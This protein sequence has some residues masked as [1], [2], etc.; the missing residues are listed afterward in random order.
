MSRYNK[1]AP[2]PHKAYDLVSSL[3]RCPAENLIT[4]GDFSCQIGLW[5]GK[6]ADRVGGWAVKQKWGCSCCRSSQF[7]PSTGSGLRASDCSVWLS[8]TN[9]S[10]RCESV[11]IGYKFSISRKKIEQN[12][13]NSGAK[14][15]INAHSKHQSEQSLLRRLIKPVKDHCT[16][17]KPVQAKTEMAASPKESFQQEPIRC[18]IN[19]WMSSHTSATMRHKWA[20][21][22]GW[23]YRRFQ[24]KR[25]RQSWGFLPV[26]P[27]ILANVMHKRSA[28]GFCGVWI[29]LLSVAHL[30]QRVN[31]RHINKLPAHTL[32]CPLTKVSSSFFANSPCFVKAS[33]HCGASQ[34]GF[35]HQIPA[36]PLLFRFGYWTSVLWR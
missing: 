25:F 8:F 27:L 34:H 10:M 18:R 28:V 21:N 33:S 13:P 14:Q 29:E 30:F 3:R 20:Q 16:S 12:P 11:W 15:G 31:F 2:C 24:L 23:E 4:V 6:C 1:G 35:A 5:S 26:F 17:G 7:R 22:Y 9:E 32:I 19:A 36:S